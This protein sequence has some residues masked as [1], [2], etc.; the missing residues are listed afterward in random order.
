[1]KGKEKIVI[2]E[3]K[4]DS[5]TGSREHIEHYDDFKIRCLTYDKRTKKYQFRSHILKDNKFLEC[6][7]TAVNKLDV[8]PD[9]E[10]IDTIRI[11]ISQKDYESITNL[12]ILCFLTNKIEIGISADGSK[13]QRTIKFNLGKAKVIDSTDACG[14]FNYEGLFNFLTSIRC[15]NGESGVFI[16]LKDRSNTVEELEANIT[17]TFKDINKIA[18]DVFFSRFNQRFTFIQEINSGVTWIYF[19]Y[20]D[21]YVNNDFNNWLFVNMRLW[22][23]AIFKVKNEDFYCDDLMRFRSK[24]EELKFEQIDGRLEY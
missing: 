23:D 22:N 20:S 5:I 1:M 13:D 15:G 21:L 17:K 10:S 3:V 18:K 19:N 6:L 11:D 16:R 14:L 4:V 9:T 7:S 12:N 8:Y 2:N 24:F